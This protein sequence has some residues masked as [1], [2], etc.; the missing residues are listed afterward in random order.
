MGMHRDLRIWKILQST[1]LSAK[2]ISIPTN[3]K[4]DKV[5]RYTRDN[6]LWERC[7]VLINNIFPCLIVLCLSDSNHAGM[8]KV[9]YYYR[10][11]NQCIERIISDIGYKNIFPDISLSTNI[12][13]MSEYEMD[14]EASLWNEYTEY[15]DNICFVL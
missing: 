10:M 13:N 9:N 6:K 14:E 7:Y 5:V 11:T 4:F 2:L 12:C 8:G 15:S 1:I 3:N